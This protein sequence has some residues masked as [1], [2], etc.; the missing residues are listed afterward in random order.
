MHFL[1]IITRRVTFQ[2]Q[3]EGHGLYHLRVN[4]ET[5]IVQAPHLS[6]PQRGE[7]LGG[8]RASGGD[9]GNYTRSTGF[10][11]IPHPARYARGR[12]K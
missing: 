3:R 12:V 1:I 8:G 6:S 5:L 7:G 2:I 11:I 9:E 10:G 4:K